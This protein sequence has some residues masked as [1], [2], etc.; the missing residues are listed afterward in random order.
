MVPVQWK[1]HKFRRGR[2]ALSYFIVNTHDQLYAF[3]TGLIETYSETNGW[4]RARPF[5]FAT[6][7]IGCRQIS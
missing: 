1:I 4:G 3:Y 2:R 6:V 7:P 5:K